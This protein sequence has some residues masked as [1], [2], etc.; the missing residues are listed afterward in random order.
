MGWKVKQGVRRTE[1]RD[2]GVMIRWRCCG[3][4]HQK[5]DSFEIELSRRLCLL[6]LLPKKWWVSENRSAAMNVPMLGLKRNG[7]LVH[8]HKPQGG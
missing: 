2:L 8:D 4:H 7:S 3:G 6:S 5:I 1:P